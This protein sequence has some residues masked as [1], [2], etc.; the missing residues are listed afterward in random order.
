MC[1][2][3]SGAKK[4]HDW[5][6]AQIADLFHT[7]HKV[8]TQKVIKSR[9]QHCGDI[10]LAGYL[11]N[12]AGP[13]PLVLDLR[14]AHDRF[15]SSSDPSLNGNLHYPNNIDGSLNE[16]TDDKIRKY[17]VDYNNNPPNTVSF[18]SVIG[19]MSGRLHSEFVRLLFLQAHRETDRF[20]AASGVQLAQH[21]RDQFH[22]RRAA[23]SAQIKA[24]VGST[25]AKAA[26]LRINLNIDGTP[27][28]SKSHTHPSHS[29][30][31]RLL[32]SSLSLG[33]PVPRATQC[34]RD[35]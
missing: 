12:E 2:T 1:T 26:V 4:T 13:V 33:V 25:L 35:M 32:T 15:G 29:Q 34:I 5:M 21:D 9:G 16:T 6:V 23:F 14:I 10:K 31:C 22:F 11:A 7:T 3:H 28:I 17:R 8:K 24:K 19:S 30:T 20:F 18:M 27:I